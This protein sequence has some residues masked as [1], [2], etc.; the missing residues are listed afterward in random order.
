MASMASLDSMASFGSVASIDSVASIG[1]VASVGSAASVGSVAS[2]EQA[3]GDDALST[4]SPAD[5]AGQPKG[6][7]KANPARGGRRGRRGGGFGGLIKVFTRP[8]PGAK[9]ETRKI[10][11]PNK[12]KATADVAT[13]KAN[14]FGKY[15]DWA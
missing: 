9:W 7:L 2:V 5:G 8:K 12:P 13:Y 6:I 1:S 10:K 3:M 11:K 15:K 4:N 14:T